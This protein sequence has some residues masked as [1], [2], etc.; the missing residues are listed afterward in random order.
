[1]KQVFKQL[2]CHHIWRWEINQGVWPTTEVCRKCGER[3][4]KG[5]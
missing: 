5:V 1:M 2:L 3:R 4:V